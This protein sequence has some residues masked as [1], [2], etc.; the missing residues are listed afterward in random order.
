[1]PGEDFFQ[2]TIR[3][4]A[5]N[6]QVPARLHAHPPIPARIFPAEFNLSVGFPDS[7]FLERIARLK[8][9]KIAT[10]AF[11]IESQRFKE[12]NKRVWGGGEEIC[13]GNSDIGAEVN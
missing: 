1:M 7:D 11:Y 6:E 8:P 3:V 10:Q 12:I 13:G 5:G 4:P 9:A 2:N